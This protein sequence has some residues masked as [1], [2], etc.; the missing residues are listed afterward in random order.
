MVLA[1]PSSEAPCCAQ[2]VNRKDLESPRDGDDQR[3]QAQ[4]Q[5]RGPGSSKDAE[6]FDRETDEVHQRGQS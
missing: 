2:G 5:E 1:K 3:R 4:G 6:V